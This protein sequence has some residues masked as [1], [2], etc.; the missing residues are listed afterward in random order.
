MNIQRKLKPFLVGNRMPLWHSNQY[1]IHLFAF[2]YIKK[3]T[4]Q[5]AQK[6][7]DQF[8]SVI[9]VLVSCLRGIDSKLRVKYCARS[10]KS[11]CPRYSGCGSSPTT[12]F[13]ECATNCVFIQFTINYNN[14][15][16]AIKLL[17][18]LYGLI[19]QFLYCTSAQYFS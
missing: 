15:E 14:T 17:I 11:A 16:I 19:E 12:E 10:L 9:T 3:N 1:N 2:I 4:Q 18:K 5:N 7:T 6:I 13:S 8:F